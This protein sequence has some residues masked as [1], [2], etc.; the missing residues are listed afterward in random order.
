MKLSFVTLM[1]RNAEKS[2][3]F[4]KELAGLTVIRSFDPG[5]GPIT[6]LA[7]GE[8]ETMIELIQPRVPIPCY[9][10]TGMTMAFMCPGEMEALAAVREKAIAM[11]YA[12]TEIVTGGPEPVNFK[13]KDPDGVNVEFCQM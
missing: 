2:V 13:V 8:G 9:E 6:F 4:Y 5:I 3:A 11:G 10:G 12:P 1:V 7:N